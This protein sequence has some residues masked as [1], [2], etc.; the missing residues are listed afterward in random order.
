M[1]GNAVR[2][3]I[4]DCHERFVIEL[5]GSGPFPGWDV[6]YADGPV[7]A[8]QSDGTVAVAGGAALLVRTNAWMQT[9]EGTGYQGPWQIL[10]A[11]LRAIKELRLVD[12]FEGQSTWA[13]GVDERR[14]FKVSVLDGP[15]R[16]VVDI[17]IRP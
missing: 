10:P 3:G 4:H 1:I 13:V 16:L 11:N 17:Q 2:T 8:G 6:A 12:N 7:Y 15:P 5:Q 9:L 14:N